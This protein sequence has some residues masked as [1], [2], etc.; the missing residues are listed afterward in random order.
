MRSNLL[1]IA[2]IIFFFFSC[3]NDQKPGIEERNDVPEIEE[4]T[5]ASNLRESLNSVKM[6]LQEK[7]S[8]IA[9]YKSNNYQPI[10]KSRELREDL[11][12]NIE[13]VETEGLFPQDY[14]SEILKKE[15]AQLD[16]TTIADRTNLEILLTDAFLKLAHD[17]G[18]GKL[19]P[20]DLH[21]IWGTPLNKVD[22]A[23]LLKK[24]IQE[25]DISEAL[26][27]LKPKHLVYTGLK[28]QLSKILADSTNFHDDKFERIGEGKL[29][30][31][32]ENDDRIP[33]VYSRLQQLD[34]IK[35]NTDSVSTTYQEDLQEPLKRF[36]QDHGLENDGIVGNT[37]V[38]EL[39]LS[40]EDRYHQILIN[41]ER[42]RWFPRDF[43]E[44]FILINI[45]NYH[46]DVIEDGD[47][48]R[49]HRTMVGTQARKTPEFSDKIKY[50]VFN[51][52]WTIPPTIKKNDIIP[53]SAKSLDYL[54]GHK[55]K[56]YDKS[57]NVIDPKSVNWK[58]GEAKNYT[59]R[60]DPGPTNPLGR[61]KIIYPNE[62]M[63][64]LHDTP[65][66]SL[67]KNNSRAR[68]SGCVRVQDALGL[69]EFL[70]NDQPKFDQEKIA[71]I[72]ESG[73]TKEVPVTRNFK[74]H[75]LYWTAYPEGDTIRFINDVY[76]YDQKLWEAFKPRN[77]K[78]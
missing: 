5:D 62:Y 53:G 22:N 29:I 56:I 40:L 14:H 6:D 47:T 9:F 10:W 59:F 45:A 18:A 38:S 35:K 76:G 15:L 52:T 75:H 1:Y 17:L 66:Q 24:A 2:V 3:K 71:E 58:N 77:S 50:V 72:L 78:K 48:V 61:V 27:N 54:K 39:N 36:Q 19:N 13:T 43:G 12:R 51:P 70:L 31:P 63:I 67:F 23:S 8:L 68:S 21:E 74:V 55:L 11:F 37:T 4:L 30:H 7:D 33:L 34:Y 46:L 41:M 25:K 26:E 64:Y 57:G 73:K 42:W 69:A 32:N 44:N 65:S 49:S 28:R 60:Q 16:K 20:K